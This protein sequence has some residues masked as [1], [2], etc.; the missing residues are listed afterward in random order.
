MQGEG[1]DKCV[2]QED[3]TRGKNSKYLELYDVIWYMIL[4]VSISLVTYFS[5]KYLEQWRMNLSNQCPVVSSRS[6]FSPQ[7]INMETAPDISSASSRCITHHQVAPSFTCLIDKTQHFGGIQW[8]FRETSGVI[9]MCID[10]VCLY[11][12]PDK[13]AKAKKVVV[14]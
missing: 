1:K 6:A 13:W 5:K 8:T 9:T 10:L 3:L 4:L 14:T 11:I 2:T 7:I 12:Y